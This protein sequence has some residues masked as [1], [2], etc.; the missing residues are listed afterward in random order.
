MLSKISFM[1]LLLASLA[2]LNFSVTLA[3]QQES[4]QT[5]LIQQKETQGSGEPTSATLQKNTNSELFSKIFK[6]IRIN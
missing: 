5:S 3:M 1:T 2:F 4:T 6:A